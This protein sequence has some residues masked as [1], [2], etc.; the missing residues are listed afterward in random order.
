MDCLSHIVALLNFSHWRI[1]KT[2]FQHSHRVWGTLLAPFRH[3]FF[4]CA[5]FSWSVANVGR[6]N[7]ITKFIC[8]NYNVSLFLRK[9][10]FSMWMANPSLWHAMPL[11]P[12]VAWLKWLLNWWLKFHARPAKGTW[13]II[14]AN[15]VANIQ[16][17]CI[18]CNV[19][20]KCICFAWADTQKQTMTFGV[21]WQVGYI[22][23]SSIYFISERRGQSSQMCRIHV[24]RHSFVTFLLQLEVSRPW[25]IHWHDASNSDLTAELVW[26][27]VNWFLWAAATVILWCR[28]TTVIVDGHSNLKLDGFWWMYFPI[29]NAQTW[30]RWDPVFRVF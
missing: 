3:D 9:L 16:A 10:K 15:P 26:S 2:G 12:V 30:W 28:C 5:K 17:F 14:F 18:W 1:Y 7:N 22:Q 19:S 11:L 29:N 23:C 21:L 8:N 24:R 4:L 20:R 25:N 13:L 6:G 27:R